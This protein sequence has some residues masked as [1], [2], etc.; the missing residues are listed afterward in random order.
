[1][2]F[3]ARKSGAVAV[4]FLIEMSCLKIDY[5]FRM[6]IE[7]MSI[8]IESVTL[9]EYNIIHTTLHTHT[10]KTS[11]FMVDWSMVVFY[12]W[13]IS[14]LKIIQRYRKKTWTISSIKLLVFC[15]CCCC[16]AITKSYQQK[17]E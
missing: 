1:M 2:A 10:H 3:F 8:D 17:C 15:R 6:H 4:D 14:C 5:E 11:S 12:L 9:N 7:I 13:K 16:C